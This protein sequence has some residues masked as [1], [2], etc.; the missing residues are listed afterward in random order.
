MRVFSWDGPID[1]VMTPN[2]SILYYKNF[3]QAGLVSIE[4][5]TG[6]VKAWVG[7]P[8]IN[9][10]K[11]DHVAQG[12]RQIGST[13]KPFIYAAGMQFGVITPC[14]TT[15][16][17]P[18]CVDVPDGANGLKQWCPRNAGEE[19]N[20]EPIT[21]T[22]GLAKSMNNITVAVMARMGGA[23]GPQ[24]V[25]KILRNLNINLDKRD[26]VPAMCLGVM[27]MSLLEL[28]SAECAFVNAGIYNAPSSI[29]R[30]ED[31]NGN[32]IY[33]NQHVSREAMSADLAY[34]TL[35][36]MRQVVLAGTGASLRGGKDWGGVTVPTA[37]KTGTTQNN[38]DGWWM[39]LTPDLVTGVWVGAEDM[40][41]HFRTM[42][43]GQGARMALPIYGYMMQKVYK[44]P[45][46]HISRKEF[47]APYGF[48]N[49]I[50]NCSPKD[51]KDD[52]NTN[53]PSD[54]LN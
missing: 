30:I 51:N 14:A 4:P 44:D 2:D 49:S 36:M 28:T 1:T 38:S 7:G 45:K 24:A 16:D 40:T 12:K 18:Y 41:V 43:W 11:Y 5:Q 8:N 42:H 10:F 39:G 25:A 20:G 13:I 53:D 48:S 26:I 31:R 37:G 34:A 27:D 9:Y 32:I 33:D 3:L 29:L 35:K 15:P 21:F 54:L 50:Y 6:L 46:I 52:G 47:K 22:R 17:I 23:A 19:M